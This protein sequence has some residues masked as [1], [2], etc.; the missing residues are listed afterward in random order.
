MSGLRATLLAGLRRHST[1]G[2][3]SRKLSEVA[4][5]LGIRRA[6]AIRALS[7]L[8]RDGA[9]V[10]EQRAARG[11]AWRLRIGGETRRVA[12]PRPPVWYEA[13]VAVRPPGNQLRRVAP[14]TFPASGFSMLGGRI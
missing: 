2:V 1:D 13:P 8:V 12:P 5:P 10:V 11:K 6:S 14:K 3:F 9:V 4:E 7:H